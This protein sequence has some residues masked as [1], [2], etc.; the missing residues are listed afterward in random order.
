[1]SCCSVFSYFFLWFLSLYAE[2][3][4]CR[5]GNK[6]HGKMAEHKW[7]KSHFKSY[8]SSVCCF[9]GN[10]RLIRCIIKACL[11]QGKYK[12]PWDRYFW[13]QNW[14]EISDIRGGGYEDNCLHHHPDG[15]GST[16][17][18]NVGL[19]QEDCTS[20]YP[21]RLSSSTKLIFAFATKP[22]GRRQNNVLPLE[23]SS[24]IVKNDLGSSFILMQIIHF[25]HM[26]VYSVK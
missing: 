2:A 16:N 18:W 22:S 5:P 13:Q 24:V 8:L 11:Q 20:L 10:F 3:C 4:E 25:L 15:E 6:Q 19:L 12:L 23:P 17:L 21:S 9:Y 7:E 1:M 14:C 26:Y